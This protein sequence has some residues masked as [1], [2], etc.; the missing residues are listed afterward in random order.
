M[1]VRRPHEEAAYPPLGRLVPVDDHRLHV[2]AE[3]QGD[4]T[5]V[6]L[7]GS[8]TTAP[9][10]DFKG[11]YSR[12]SDGYRT[13]VVERAGYGC[14]EDGGTPRGI[15]TDLNETRPALASAGESPPY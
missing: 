14:S 11:L 1:A 7:T 2:Y 10:P 9:A 12:L 4:S 5:L 6:F 15:D 3:G 8:G 13:V